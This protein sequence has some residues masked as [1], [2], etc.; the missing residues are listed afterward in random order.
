[1]RKLFALVF[2]VIVLAIGVSAAEIVVYENDFSTS[3]ISDLRMHGT[4]RVVDGGLKAIGSGASAYVAYELPKEYEGMDY[5]VDVDIIN[6][7]AMA[8]VLVGATSDALK[9]EPSYFSGYVATTSGGGKVYHAYFSETGWGGTF[10]PNS[11]PIPKDIHLSVTVYKGASTLRVTSLNGGEFI[12]E[13]RYEPGDGE[14]DIYTTFTSE[15]GLRQYYSDEGYLD[16]FKVTVLVDDKL[17]AMDTS[18]TLGNTEF[19]ASGIT[20][21]DGVA[22]GNG[23]MLSANALTGEYRIT[24]SLASENVSRV[25][26]GM[27]DE[28]NG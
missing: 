8:G 26:F 22:T 16:N 14:G 4:M 7:T 18:V 2:A 20:V 25:Y 21:R 6:N 24:A 3:D 11:D 10:A 12:Y 19:K 15:T 1:M 9:N 28:K 23:A 5:R 27:Q 13:S 17:P